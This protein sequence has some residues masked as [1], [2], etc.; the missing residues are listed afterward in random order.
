[1]SKISKI[2]LLLL[3]FQCSFND[4][5]R[6]W[7]QKKDLEQSNSEYKKLFEN[8][9][10]ETKEF[11]K[12]FSIQISK[13]DDGVNKFSYFDNNDGFQNFNN[14]L[15]Q[16]SKFK[17][18][19][20]NNFEKI[21]PTLIFSNNNIIFFDNKGSI[22]NLDEKSNLVW[23]T[24][25]YTKSEKKLQPLINL[26]KK[27]NL[28]IA[29]DNLGKYYA[30]NLKT[31]NILW[32]KENSS[33]F[34]SQ[35]K[36]YK[37]CILIIDSNNSLKC[38]SLKNGEEIWSHNT[39]KP[40]ISSTKKLSM[41]IKDDQVIFSNSIGDLTSVNI[42]NGDLIWQMSTR[43][44]D[45]FEEIMNLKS[46]NIILNESSIYF[47]NNKNE[48]YSIDISTGL[49]NWT[50]EINSNLKPA[51]IDDL[52][53][54]I[55]A[56]GYLFLIEKNSGNILRITNLFKSIKNKKRKNLL[57]TG[58]ILNQENIFVST[59]KGFILVA[60]IKKGIANNFYKIDNNKISRP[61][62][63]NKHFYLVRDNS[64]LKLN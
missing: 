16:V 12:D 33:P 17:F 11:N 14:K 45:L 8:K 39:E 42:N 6:F 20:I 60:D 3:L 21:E 5:N 43:N 24:N 27:K 30:I 36:I 19:K 29:A 40:F 46:S 35:I 34:N 22:F 62:I 59:N 15:H 57:P 56:K 18:S 54:T 52:I 25:I 41:V 10:K 48:F 4:N 53:L 47:S 55:S 44:T 61:F 31:G 51:I 28:I 2:F 63:N 64:I 38:Y 32:K 37:N 50:Q 9:Q 23:K 1:M 26:D 13:S 7:S 58:F 49:I